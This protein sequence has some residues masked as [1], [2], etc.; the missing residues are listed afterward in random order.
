VTDLPLP[1]PGCDACAA[2]DSVIAELREEIGELQAAVARPSRRS[3][4]H[5]RL[6][7]R[8]V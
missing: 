5:L 8:V 3:Q 4:H 1:A 2:R 6:A 7:W